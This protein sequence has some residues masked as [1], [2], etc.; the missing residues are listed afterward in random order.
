[1]A[2]TGSKT[3]TSTLAMH[4]LRM[5][6]A[7]MSTAERDAV[8][9]LLDDLQ[10]QD[11]GGSGPRLADL[12]E[13]PSVTSFI[14]KPGIGDL[15]TPNP[16]PQ[17]AFVNSSV[18]EILYGGKA[19]G[20]KALPLTSRQHL[21]PVPETPVTLMMRVFLMRSALHL[22]SSVMWTARTTA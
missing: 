1:M 7:Q 11:G 3:D 9:A 16:G 13:T 6:L 22:S 21:M 12:L 2:K 19:G 15:F 18:T 20:G 14:D 4:E 5:R 17:T 10:R 8:L